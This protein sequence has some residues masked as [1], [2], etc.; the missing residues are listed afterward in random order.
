MNKKIDREDNDEESIEC[1]WQK[2]EEKI[3]KE[4]SGE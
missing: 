3:L 2:E 1:L 4:Y